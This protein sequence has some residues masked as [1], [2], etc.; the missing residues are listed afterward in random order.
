M[1]WGSFI[2]GVVAAV[3]LGGAVALLFGVFGDNDWFD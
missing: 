2:W 3:A 1:D